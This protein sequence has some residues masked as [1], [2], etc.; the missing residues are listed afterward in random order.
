M[1]WNPCPQFVAK[2]PLLKCACAFRAAAVASGRRAH[3]EIWTL[4]LSPFLSLS[5]SPTSLSF[6][7]S[8]SLSLSFSLSPPLSLPLSLSLPPSA[9]KVILFLNMKFSPKAESVPELQVALYI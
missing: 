6:P 9:G 8:P 2:A 1:L 7:L 3:S 5:R 4:S